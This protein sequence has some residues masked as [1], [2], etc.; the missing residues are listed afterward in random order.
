MDYAGAVREEED[1]LARRIFLSRTPANSIFRACVRRFGCRVAE[2]VC[3]KSPAAACAPERLRSVNGIRS[4]KRFALHGYRSTHP[5]RYTWGDIRCT[6][7]DLRFCASSPNHM[8]RTVKA[9]LA[10]NARL[11]K[12]VGSARMPHRT[13]IPRFVS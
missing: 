10:G 6:S 7:N 9:I 12:V 1:L 5:L 13:P 8:H 4:V 3:W 2:Y 11:Y